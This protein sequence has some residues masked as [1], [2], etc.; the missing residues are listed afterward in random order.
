MLNNLQ[1]LRAVAALLVVLVH[2]GAITHLGVGTLFAFGHSGV[3]LF[4]V[5]SGFVMVYT[6]ARRPLSPGGFLLNRIIRVVPLYWAF[7]IALFVVTFATGYPLMQSTRPTT[8]EFI[9][10]LAFIPFRKA[11]G[12]MQPLYFLGWTLNYEMMFYVLFTAAIA[13]G[14]GRVTRVVGVAL[15]AVVALAVAGWVFTPAVAWLSFY[16]GS[17]VLAFAVGMV[18]ALLSLRG[19]VLPRRIAGAALAISAVALLIAPS[20]GFRLHS[21]W[22]GL[23]SGM[24]VAAAVALEQGGWRARSPSALLLG[25]ASYALYLSHPFATALSDRVSAH[26]PP[27]FAL[28]VALAISLL[29]A[30]ALALAIHFAFERPVTAVLRKLVDHRRPVLDEAEDGVVHALLHEDARQ[31]AAAQGAAQIRG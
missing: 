2:V 1:A 20:L 26:V 23:V 10:S 13:V 18:V 3:D 8:V 19:I 21:P 31:D 6:F 22:I 5:I 24:A 29:V 28:P 15:A 17:I 30:I 27:V 9:Q 4:F 11:D 7:T 16:T 14:G 25:A 12:V